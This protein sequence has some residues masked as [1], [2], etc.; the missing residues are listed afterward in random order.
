MKPID[1]ERHEITTV[2]FKEDYVQ[3]LF[4]GDCKEEILT[5]YNFPAIIVGGIEFN[6]NKFGYQDMLCSLISKKV[7]KSEITDGTIK[8]MFE[9]Y[10]ELLIP[11]ESS[12]GTEAAMLRV[13]GYENH[14]MV[15]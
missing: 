3:F 1:L 14:M 13:T 8:I 11:L 5:A 7:K 4:E 12:Y 9:N 6:K 10:G 15:W 2:V